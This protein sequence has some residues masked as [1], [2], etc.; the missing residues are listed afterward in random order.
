MKAKALLFRG[1]HE[2]VLWTLRQIGQ[3]LGNESR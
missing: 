3:T 2:K 1:R